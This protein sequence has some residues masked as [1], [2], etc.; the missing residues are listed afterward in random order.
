MARWRAVLDLLGDYPDIIAA[1]R[2]AHSRYESLVVRVVSV[3]S[4]EIAEEESRT[5]K[6]Q[7]RRRFYDSE[8]E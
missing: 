4:D 1:R 7:R 5:A 6:A 2:E 3:A 8:A